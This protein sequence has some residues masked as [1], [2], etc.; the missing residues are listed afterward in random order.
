MAGVG[1][2][3]A[4]G[5]LGP[6]GAQQPRAGGR[7]VVALLQRVAQGHHRAGP[8]LG[9]LV[10]QQRVAPAGALEQRGVVLALARAPVQ[11]DD[12]GRQRVAARGGGRSVARGVV[13]DQ[14]LGLEGQGLALGRDGV[15]A[16]HEQLALLGVDDAEGEL[17]SHRGR[18]LSPLRCA[19]ASSTPPPTR[20]PT[21]GRCALR[22]RRR[23]REVELVTA[24]V[25]AR[26]GA[27]RA[28]LHG[29]R[30]LLPLRPEGPRPALGAAGPAHPR[31]A[32]RRRAARP[33][34][35]TSSGWRCSRSTSTCCAPTA[36]RASSPPTTCSRASPGR[37]SSTP[38]A[39]ST[40]AWTR[41]SCTP[42]TGARG[43]STSS[44]LPAAA[45][46]RH[47][48]RDPAPAPATPRCRPSCR[49]YDGTVVLCFGLLRPY[50]GIDVL[51][52]AWQG[53]EDAELWIVGRRAHGHRAAAR[54]RAAGRALRRALRQR[55]RG[56][57]ALPPRRPRRAALPRDRA[58]G[59][60]LHRAGLRR[61]A[62]AHR[63]RRLPRGRGRRRGRARRAG[64]R[65]G[66]AR[67]PREPARRP[68]APRHA[69]DGAR[70]AWPTR[71]TAG[72]RSRART[73]SST[74]R[75]WRDRGRRRLLGRP[76]ACS[77]TRRSATRCC[78][79]C[80]A[81][82]AAGAAST[83]PRPTAP[84]RRC[85]SSSPRTAR[86]R[87][88]RRRSPTRARSTGPP[89][90]W[91]SSSPATARPTTRPARARAAG[92]DV[93]LDLPWGGKVRAQDAAVE[94]AGGELLAFS[95][96][97]AL[98]E[99]GALR[100][101]AARLR[102][103]RR[104]LRLRAGALRQ[105]RRDQPGGP[106]LALRDGHPRA[107]SRSW[108]RSPPATARSTRCAPRPTCASTR[109]WATTSRC[110]STWSSAA[111]ARSTPRR[112]ARPRRWCPPWRASSPASGA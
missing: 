40:S 105:R 73:S 8:Q 6:V 42:S 63:R 47:P 79:S 16:A 7:G 56:R 80:S 17:D 61:P 48:A 104:R 14:D 62:R 43:W 81:A 25:P 78:S 23:G 70:C 66:A 4:L 65:G 103:R 31:H 49:D 46:P 13:E 71:R 98:W 19:S 36:T 111:G 20:R 44:A 33:T 93:V 92:A 45:R 22:W 10:E 51:V 60:P 106:V 15:Q 82:R 69:G 85:R 41:S 94:R 53:I 75:C 109:S 1:K 77:P 89:S 12:L 29:A 5:W 110:P 64:R 30:G 2:R 87:S 100:A 24:P 86:R 3:H 37:A 9:V 95:D 67:R 88:S 96:A 55:G 74:T 35:C 54:R 102:R 101:L 18:L 97:N 28:G 108:R 58:V 90:A 91:R 50:K 32:A 27:A 84:S 72:T 39:S 57:G 112:R 38:S 107:A 52:E 76:P 83:P 68:R 99:P 21:T 11:R 59:R 34:S 26:R